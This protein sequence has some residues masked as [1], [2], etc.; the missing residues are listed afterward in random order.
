MEPTEKKP[1]IIAVYLPQYHE[2]EDNDRWWGKGYTDWEAVK[3]AKPLFKGHA[4]PNVPLHENYYDLSRK[5]SIAAQ[6]QLARE[7]GIDGFCF[8]HYWFKDGKKELEKPAE[9]LLAEKDI[10]IRFCFNW[11]N[12]SWIRSWSNI[13][14]NVW[15][16]AFE[17]TGADTN[18]G[19]LVEQD[20]GGEADWD[21][22][23]YY[24]LPFFKDSR[25]IKIEDKPIFIFYRPMDI[26]CLTKMTDRWN[27][28]AQT[29]G[30][31][32][33]YFITAK[34][35]ASWV[36]LD[37]SL[38]Y[39]PRNAVDCLNEDSRVTVHDGVRCFEYA[40]IWNAILQSSPYQGSKTYFMGVAGYD[41]TPRRG[42]RGECFINNTPDIFAKNMQLLIEKSMACRNSLVFVNAWNEWGEGMYLEPDERNRYAYLQGVKKAREEASLAHYTKPVADETG[43]IDQERSELFYNENKYRKFLDVFNQWL[44]MER[45]GQFA[46]KE[47][48]EQQRIHSVAIYGLGLLGKQLY[49]ELTFVGVP[50]AY[51]IDRYVGRYRNNLPII[52]PEDNH[53]PPVDAVIVTAYEE[54]SIADFVSGK[55]SGKVIKLTQCIDDLQELQSKG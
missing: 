24:L 2:T 33:I 3:K 48:L 5:E 53:W 44:T 50:V 6:A 13:S 43:D 54:D 36:G 34:I 42:R 49:Q 47:Y 18:A 30:L 15:G 38:I 52:R 8:Y 40:D 1:E 32:G 45:N 20:Y 46:I 28:L 31:E 41:D 19:V 23:F 16:E 39:Q 25:Y 37:A 12:E 14:G 17:Q 7:Y 9:I 27:E 29:E 51:A 10:D 35:N 4:V 21:R 22:H 26:P 11:A 55:I